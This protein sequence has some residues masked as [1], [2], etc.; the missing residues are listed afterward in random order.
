M[1]VRIKTII[2][3]EMTPN[4]PIIT[5][6]EIVSAKRDILNE[7]RERIFERAS[8]SQAYPLEYYIKDKNK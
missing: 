7:I 1:K 3:T 4:G 6:Q 5:D 8:R 2:K